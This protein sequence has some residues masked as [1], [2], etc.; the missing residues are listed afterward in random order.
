MWF[1]DKLI[2]AAILPGSRE[3]TLAEKMKESKATSSRRNFLKGSGLAAIASTLAA[4]ALAESATAHLSG[5]L[6]HS[7]NPSST[8]ATPVDAVNVLQG[9]NSSHAFSRGNTL[10]I[11]A[12]PFG[13]AHWTLQSEANTP[14][15]FSPAARRIQGLRCT[16]QLSPWL[17]DYGHAVFMP[18]CGDIQPEAAARASSYRPGD[19]RLTPYSFELFLLRYR[20]RV[21]LIP[22]ERCCLLTANFHAD[23][24]LKPTGLAFDVLGKDTRIKPDPANRR[25]LFTSTANA[26]GVP[27]NFATYYI[28]QFDDAWESFEVVQPSKAHPG[29]HQIG[30]VKFKPGT[31][32]EARI[33]TSFLSFD[34]ALLNLKNE[35]GN[36]SAESLRDKAK[37]RWNEH[38]NRIEI[39][40]ATRDQYRTF[41]SCLYRA[42][43]FPRIWHEP[44][45][46]G[47]MHHFSAF[48]GK[49][50]PGVMYADHGYWDVYRAW[51]PFMS[52]V[53]PER[54]GEILQ[55]WVNAYQEGGWLPQFPAPGYRACMTGSLID[56]VF[57]DAA[58]KGITGFDIHAAYEGLK[59][60]ATLKGD[61]DKG[62]GRA[63]I[64]DY[65][66]LGYIPADRLEQSVAETVDAAYGDF[67]IAQVA[68]AAGHEDDYRLFLK[69]SENW[70]KLFDPSVKFLRGKNANGSWL[71]P[72]DPF[73]WGSP[74][75][76]G[77]AWQHRWDAPH[78]VPELI[79]AM[80]SNAAAADAL[81]KMLSTPPIF[82]VGVYEQEI[83]EMSEMAAVDFGQYAH[84]NQP[85]HNL[86]YLFAH[87]GR[88]DR[89]Q[90]WVRRVM[91]DLYS[92]DNFAGDEDTGSMAAWYLLSAMGFYPV[93]PGKA[94]Y[95]LGIP[96]F[97]HATL[98]L[99][100]GKT[101][102]IETTINDSE[103]LYVRDVDLNGQS[104]AGPTMSHAAV[105]GGGTL[106][107]EMA[108]M[109]PK[110]AP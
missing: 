73:T 24:G 44:D 101:L 2:V 104:I 58:A 16:H 83:H 30:I 48:N 22:T 39:E 66:K 87:A 85:S 19:A 43:L 68:K 62:Y 9:T 37:S 80:G 34:Q 51:Y 27:E 54:L 97:P 53:F 49:V 40:G 20:A 71:A 50:V 79:E 6:A 99:S 42:L 11:A 107:F 14:W 109:P 3:K 4:P 21:E 7:E 1:C 88:A 32:I 41:Y 52:I 84:S 67:C 23:D 55:A 64:E 63:G 65:L 15:M 72:F 38:L 86:L 25:I 5:D 108:A 18:Y 45:A 59:K 74:Y 82:N 78:A 110:S 102:I 100:G 35:L 103:K 70:R 92:P 96:L 77:S 69:R 60:H 105:I 26:G 106:R 89:T 10:P 46:Q 28:L 31:A 75:V 33:A 36:H 95:T 93:C 17:D 57:G 47:Q 12:L 90:Y 98:R 76:E 56:S 13:M 29:N 61:P 91:R 94:E 8:F 81:E